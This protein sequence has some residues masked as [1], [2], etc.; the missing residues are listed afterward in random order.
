MGLLR[1][2]AQELREK[3]TYEALLVGAIS[4]DELNTLALPRV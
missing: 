3:G 4:F 1:R 2:I